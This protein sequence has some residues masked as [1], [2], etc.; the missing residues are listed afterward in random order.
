MI[1]TSVQEDLQEIRSE[2]ESSSFEDQNCLVTG[3][4][5]FLGSWLC[6]IFLLA[7]AKVCCIDNLSSGSLEN[8]N[9]LKRNKHF[10]IRRVD[11]TNHSEPRE[12]FHYIL[13]LASRVSP[14]DYQEHPIETLLTNSTGTK[15]MLELARKN[16][17]VLLYTSS[18]EI[19]G[20]S[21]II[22]TPETYYG[23][24][25]PIG[26][27]SCYDEG[28]RFGE[29]L[30]IAYY[31]TYG[32]DVRITRIFNSYGPRMRADGAYARAIPRFISQGLASQDITVYGNGSQTR[33]FCYVTD[34]ITAIVKTLQTLSMKGEVVNIGNPEETS[35]LTLAQQILSLTKSNSRITFHPRP[36]DDP[37]RRCPDMSRAKKKLKWEPRV[38]LEQ[39]LQKTI[40]WFRDYS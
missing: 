32:L 11:V 4:A 26:S 38:T 28:K 29:A 31:K 3:G 13:H 16:D 8:I 14:E 2:L 1:G 25:N 22:P 9:H 40:S 30:C 5:G 12:K 37:Q 27:R 23:Y 35:I 20:N 34:T 39:G 24:V 6:D 15:D 19:Y 18:S 10:T 21:E 33:S 17:S 36:Q 7:G